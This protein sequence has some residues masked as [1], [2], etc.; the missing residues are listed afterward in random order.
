[1][2]SAPAVG[3]EPVLLLI[4]GG[5]DS[6]VVGALLLHALDPEQVH[7]MYVDTGLMRKGE[8]PRK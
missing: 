6:T 4:S 1:M 5:V 3:D 8:S 7:L 2:R